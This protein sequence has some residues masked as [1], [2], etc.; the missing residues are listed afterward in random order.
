MSAATALASVPFDP[1]SDVMLQLETDANINSMQIVLVDGVLDGELLSR[2]AR[3]IAPFWKRIE[4]DI[5]S[6]EAATNL[7]LENPKDL[8]AAISSFADKRL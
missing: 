1:P 3:D 7:Q 4:V 6:V 2:A 5:Y 8:A